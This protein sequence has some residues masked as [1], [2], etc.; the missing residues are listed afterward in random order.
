MTDCV[1]VAKKHLK[2]LTPDRIEEISK[3]PDF[4][5]LEKWILYYT[6]AKKRY[7]VNTCMKLNISEKQ[8]F[9]TLRETLTKLYYIENLQNVQF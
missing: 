7:V 8:F 6:Y 9:I 5:Y 2:S 1:Q 4:E 3:H